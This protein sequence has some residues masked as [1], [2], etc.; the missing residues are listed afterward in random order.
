MMSSTSLVDSTKEILI[1]MRG[2]TICQ[3]KTILKKQMKKISLGV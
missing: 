1:T 2:L 3:E